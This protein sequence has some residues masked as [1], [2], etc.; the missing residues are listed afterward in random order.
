MVV[1]VSKGAG[2]AI[3]NDPAFIASQYRVPSVEYR[4]SM[5]YAASHL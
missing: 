5:I 4:I 2:A 1:Q 3:F